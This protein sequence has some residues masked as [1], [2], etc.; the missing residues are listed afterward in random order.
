MAGELE[1]AVREIF[2]GL[3]RKDLEAAMRITDD[4]VQGVD[5][6]SRKWLRGRDELAE[7]LRGLMPMVEDVDTELHDVRETV[8]GDAGVFT[9]WLEQ[10]YK[11][12][13]NNQHVSAP[14][15]VL[16]RRREDGWKMVL[17]H[18]IPLSEEEAQ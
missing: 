14:T 10:D 2:D 7:Y 11:L 17:F 1:T 3:K 15:T 5:E 18:S 6:I 4:E 16:F 13:G 9:C 12:E 8:F